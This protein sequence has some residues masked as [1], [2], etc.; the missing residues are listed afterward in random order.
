M[1]FK[2]V[3][4]QH[5]HNRFAYADTHAQIVHSLTADKCQCLNEDGLGHF[6]SYFTKTTI[7]M[8]SSRWSSRGMITHY[9][10]HCGMDIVNALQ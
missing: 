9:T 1:T 2:L 10:I 5:S 3:V 8:Y 6:T 7:Y 4:K